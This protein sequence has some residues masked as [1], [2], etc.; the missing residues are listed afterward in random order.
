MLL[1]INGDEIAGGACCIN[2]FVQSN[3]D[4]RHTSAADKAHPENIMHSNG[5]Y[6]SRLLNLALRVEA[7]VKK[8]NHDIFD[9]VEEFVVTKLPKLKSMYTVICVGLMPGVDVP[10]LNALV[11][12]LKIYKLTFIF[13]NTRKPLLKSADL[14]FTNLLDLTNESECFV[15]WCKQNKQVLK[16]EKYPDSNAHNAWAKFIFNKMVEH[17]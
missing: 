13:Y 9:E 8:S 4:H 11:K 3:D 14:E 7:G 1:Y 5:Y 15:P 10:R 17:L 2:D 16:N 12:L 6:L